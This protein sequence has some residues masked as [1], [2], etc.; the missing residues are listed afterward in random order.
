M[1]DRQAAVHLILAIILRVLFATVVRYV[2]LVQCQ[3]YDLSTYTD[4]QAHRLLS[5]K[6][7]FSSSCCCHRNT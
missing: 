7:G 5:G 1:I 6:R 3:I 4:Q 2:A